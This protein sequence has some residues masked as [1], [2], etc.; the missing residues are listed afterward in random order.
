L[1]GPGAIGAGPLSFLSPE[2]A[3]VALVV[4]VPLAAL[5]TVT[6]R[7][8]DLRSLLGFQ[9]PASVLRAGAIALVVVGLLVGLAAAQP[10][11]AQTRTQ[12][13]RTDAEMYF[14]LDTS[15]SMLA[16][17]G[18]SGRVRLER[19]KDEALDL[20]ERFPEIP[21]GV[22]SI[23]D[24]PL[25]HLFPSADEQAFRATV[26]QAVA[27]EQ[28]P[29]IASFRTKSSTLATLSA[30]ATRGFYTPSARQRVLVVL[31]DGESRPFDAAA[32]GIVLRRGNGIKPVF[33][34]VWR[35]DELVYTDGAPEPN[36]R[37][38]PAST[39]FLAHVASAAGGSS[40]DEHDLSGAAA[41][42]RRDLGAGP[43]RAA[44]ASRAELA[45]GPYVLL[46]SALPLLFLL[47]RR[48]R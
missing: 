45:L 16:S 34:H 35:K 11:W 33:V 30:V 23:T 1:T 40:F 43:T 28:P 39:A 9:E 25:P 20:R 10:I 15:R 2:A 22:A 27:I 26:G 7:A 24:R 5:V 47:A 38:D 32:L 44:Q 31:T 37:P 46:A 14:V 17:S 41:A 42:I 29:P 19:A 48:S 4:L 3:L 13:V 8:R 12:R 18:A 36:Y 21:A 6:R